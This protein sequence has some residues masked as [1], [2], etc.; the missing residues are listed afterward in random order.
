MAFSIL[1]SSILVS[2]SFKILPVESKVSVNIPNLNSAMYS[3]YVLIIISFSLVY[4]PIVT[5][6]TPVAIGSSVP[7]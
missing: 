2:F 4:R 6:K 5:T 1:F 7:V 3:L